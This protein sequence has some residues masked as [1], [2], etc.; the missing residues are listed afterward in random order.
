MANVVATFTANIAPFQ[1]AMGSL[2][3]SVKA[4]T[5]AASNAGQRV[6]GAMASI[7]KASTIAGVAVGAMAAGAIKSYGTFQESINKAAVIAGSSNKSLKGDM[8]D[9]ETEALSLGKTLPI[10]A[11]D[12]G[13]AM[14]EMARNGASIKDLKTEFP[15]IA[16][17]SAV[18][19][20]D[21]AGTATTVQQAM[22]IWGGGAKNAA[23]DSAILAL[24]A[25]MSNAEVEDMGQ[26]FANVG[27]TAATLGIGIKDTSTAIGLMSNAGLG[28][29]QG[30]QDLAHALT[31]MARPSKVAAGEMQ[32]LGITYT[33]AQGKFKPFPQILKE[34]AKA[35]DGM[36]KS[37]KVAAL[38][39]LYGAAGAK[40]M[41]PLLIQTEKK[42]KSGKS[43]WD[44]Y[45]D[46]LGKVSSSSKAANKYLSDNSSNMTKNVGQSISQ[47]E[48]A[49]DSV[50]KTSIGT[51]AP[52][53][54]SVANALGNFATWLNKSKSPMAGF[55]KG[56]IAWS[57]VIAIALVAFGLLSS[58]LGKLI[59]TIS[60]PVRLI[61][62]LG[63]SASS[64][65]K[66]MAAS[67]GQIAAMGAKAAGAGLGIGLA[68]AGFAALAFGVA[69]L[70][71]TGTAGLVALAAMTASIVVI[72]AVLK[73]VAPTLTANAT[74]L[75]AMGAAVLMA[76]V[77]IALLVV[78]LT[79]FQKAGGN[80]TTLVLAIGVAIG[81]LALIFAVVAPA[82]TAGAVGMLAF[83]AAVLLVGA[84]IALATAGLALLATQLP[85]IATYGT[86]AAVGI[87]ALGGALIVFGAGALVAGAGA[88]VLGAGLAIAAAAIVLAGVAVVVL[89]AGVAVLAVGIA[90]AGAASLLLGAGL[91]LVATSGAAAGGAL[92]AAAA[93]GAAN[94]VAD[95]AG[96]VAAL[97]Y[98][99]ALVA[100][101]AGG[102]LAGAALVV[103]G[104]G[105]VV[106]GAGLVVLAAGIALVGGAIKIL[107]SGLRS[108]GSVVSSIFHGIV[109]TISGAMSSAKGAVS[110][111]ISGIKGLFSGAGGILI[112]AGR[113]IMDGLLNG[114]K[115]AWGAVK[116][117]VG[118]IAS[119]IKQ[120]KGP[121]S[122]D[123]K[124]L[125]PAGN[126]IMGGLNQGLQKS[127]GAVQKTVSGMASDISDNMSANISN[128]SMAGTQFSSGDVTQSIDA[129]ER[130]TP[131]IY[132][133]NNVDKNGINSM[134]KEADANDAAVSSYFRPIG[135]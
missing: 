31:L 92:L 64:L 114:L 10:S 106:G 43:G 75:L 16:K 23:K 55:V 124:L 72:L 41:L 135:G 79:N 25:N 88:I 20:A 58:G 18:A 34:V 122:Y 32:E 86:S 113:A 76:S 49:F 30:S 121:I 108:L 110:G 103:L 95:A 70:A 65:P 17:A 26:A 21:L 80:A 118:G 4:G 73:L 81:G 115:A 134:V 47:M 60:A 71:K 52:Q 127:F 50:I 77:G 59:K 83:G 104:A 15:A 27:S 74:G 97:A 54:Q 129:S 82:L 56:L 44:A 85:T 112:G 29:A 24:N 105:G 40:A 33:D 98:G 57:P 22:N 100:L 132:V 126:A 19:G 53:I 28:A 11:Q 130:I 102:A 2:A 36:S 42:T 8:K 46:S 14:I 123:A 48:D 35:T 51:I 3:T 120:H 69:A 1:S 13:N 66:P 117:F 38:T 84:G 116:G 7:G 89:A 111:G 125:I 63:K 78:A 93:A 6:G 68:A 5:D 131:N 12:A 87:L 45:S 119:W 99:V 107:A 9:L 67:A 128:L 94:A 39:N 37:Q 91:A 133:Q 62:G 109:N 96:A 101:A 61:K 90:L